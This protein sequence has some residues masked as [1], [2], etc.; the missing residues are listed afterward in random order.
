M[1]R[2]HAANAIGD[3]LVTISL[4]GTLFLNVSPGTAR[5]RVAIYLISTMAPFAV[6]APV[7]GPLLDRAR[8]GR[9]A[10]LAITML[11]RAIL[12]LAMGAAAGGL[13]LYPA[14][15][16]VLVLSK[17]YGVARS[18]ALPRVLPES[19]T[20]VGGNARMTTTSL[21]G[22][23]IA[24][25]IGAVLNAW[26]GY[27]WTL[28]IAMVVFVIGALLV[29]QL[30]KKVNEP[31]P[32]EPAVR[33]V[34]G[35]VL[36]PGKLA[37]RTTVP[38]RV[39]LLC[40]LALRALV[41]FL[42]TFLAFLVRQSTAGG[43]GL[44]LVVGAAA[45]GGAIGTGIGVAVRRAAP[46]VI[47]LWT[48][49]GA[50]LAC[51]LTARWFT[52]GTAAAVALVSALTSALGK[53]ALDATLQRDIPESVRAQAFARSETTLQ[54]GWVAGGALGL[55]LPLRGGLGLGL[56]AVGLTAAAVIALRTRQNAPVA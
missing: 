19:M 42:T 47:A 39:T 33:D 17:G 3:A 49:T 22:A 43:T 56:A 52:L 29:A 28:R 27:R 54:L 44:A 38:V 31:A 4:A 14:A 7:I 32:E 55:A 25:S 26:F 1:T 8:Q 50:V 35:N 36:H 37:P 45:L 16:G 46:D 5:G 6:L 13:G 34:G 23:T 10:V 40:Q 41:G 15:F 12:A 48:V 18:A 53:L 21:V 9:R 11:G 30:P 2:V 51:A 24:G 20:L